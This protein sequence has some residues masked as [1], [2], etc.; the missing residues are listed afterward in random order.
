MPKIVN[1]PSCWTVIGKLRNE[2]W[3][4][5]LPTCDDLIYQLRIAV[6]LVLQ[7]AFSTTGRIGGHLIKIPKG[8][9]LRGPAR[10]LAETNSA[11]QQR[12]QNSGGKCGTSSLHHAS[13]LA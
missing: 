5:G 9:F 6:T 11:R 1:R 12:T 13:I 8:K 7:P 2:D 4:R 10:S 3:N